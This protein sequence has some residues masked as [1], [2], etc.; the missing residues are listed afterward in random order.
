MIIEHLGDIISWLQKG[1]KVYSVSTLIDTILG[2][3]PNTRLKQN[4]QIRET[5]FS[6][7][8]FIEMTMHP[9]T[10]T[11]LANIA[12]ISHDNQFCEGF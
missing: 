10:T 5:T 6:F 12:A 4:D 2:T 7:G 3:L 9:P 11:S 1:N 8:N